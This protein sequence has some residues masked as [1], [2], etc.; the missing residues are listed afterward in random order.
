M[1]A[2]ATCQPVSPYFAEQG[3]F[4]GGQLGRVVYAK[5]ALIATLRAHYCITRLNAQAHQIAA[6]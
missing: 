5:Q 3:V 4:C 1:N 2:Y 6:E